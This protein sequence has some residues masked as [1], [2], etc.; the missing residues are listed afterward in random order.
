MFSLI[1]WDGGPVRRSSIVSFISTKSFI[2]FGSPG[3]VVVR[4]EEPVLESVQRHLVPLTRPEPNWGHFGSALTSL[5]VAIC[6]H[7]LMLA[8]HHVM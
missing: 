4:T 1:S 7:R 6:V 3:P 8:Q 5:T 2:L